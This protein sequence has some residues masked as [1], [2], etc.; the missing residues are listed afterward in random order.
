MGLG[1]VIVLER[2]IEGVE[3][4][5]LDGRKLAAVRHTLDSIA[6]EHDLPGLGEFVAFSHE[7]AETLA[8][9][10][11]FDAPTVGPQSGRW[12]ASADGLEV[13]RAIR[14]SLNDDP[15]EVEEAEALVSE[16]E[17]AEKILAAAEAQNVRF[18][19]SLEY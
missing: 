14:D 12:F 5:L 17:V 7:E 13:I 19:I 4:R 8:A 15:D 9:D 16:L 3:P 18:R 11:K 1:F 6:H 10:M 2:E